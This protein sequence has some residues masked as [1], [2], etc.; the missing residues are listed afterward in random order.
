MSQFVEQAQRR[1]LPLSEAKTLKEA[2]AEWGFTGITEDHEEPI[3][4]CRLCGKDGLRYH[5]QIRNECNG[6]TLMVGSHC[7]LRFELAVYSEQGVRL[8]LADA[9]KHLN[10]R[11]KRMHYDA[12]I[13]ALEELSSSENSEI[14]SGALDYYREHRCLTPAQAAVVVWRLKANGVEH[15][16]DFFKLRWRQKDRDAIYKMEEWRVHRIWPMF[17]AKQ[18]EAVVAMGKSPPK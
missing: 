14:L 3:E 5:F 2:F 9:K 18:K 8:S 4:T 17:N 16:I 13:R 1:I 7:I 11:M 15:K 12:C 6:N 10:S